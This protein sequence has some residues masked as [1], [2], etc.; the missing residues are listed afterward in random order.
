MIS[1]RNAQAGHVG[2]FARIS[3]MYFIVEEKIEIKERVSNLRIVYVQQDD[4]FSL[5]ELSAIDD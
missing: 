4:M 3:L 2:L 1:A 5:A